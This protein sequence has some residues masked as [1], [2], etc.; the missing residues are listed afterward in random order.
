MKRETHTIDAANKILGR[1]AVEVANL[2]RGKNKLD[3]GANKD[4]GDFVIIKNI[5]KI[6]VTGKKFDNKMY[7]H[8]SGYMGGL[9][10]V[11]YKK[12]FKKNPGE[13]LKKAVFGMMP[14]NKLRA[15][16]I[17]RLKFENGNS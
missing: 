13:V 9:K 7:Y 16:Q 12:L 3:F 1:L 2:L 11:P 14:K 17:K 10:E 5:K 15:R 6:I 4:V 8:H